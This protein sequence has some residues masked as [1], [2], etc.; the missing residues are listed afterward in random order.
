MDSLKKAAIPQ[1]IVPF[2]W[3]ADN[4]EEAVSFYTGCF[5][6]SKIESITRYDETSAK[7]SGRP[8][9]SLMTESFQ[10][11][12]QN[13]IALN[14]GPVFKFNPAISFYVNCQTE[15]ET[16][17]LWQKLSV[18]GKAL[19]PLDAY[20]FSKKFGW[21]QDQ[22]GLSWQVNFTGSAQKISPFLMFTGQQYGKAEEAMNFYTSLFKSSEILNVS[23]FGAGSNETEGA[24][25]HARFT[26]DG[27]EFMAM[28]SKQAHD[29]S[30]TPAISF[31][32]YCETQEEIDH[33]WNKLTDGGKEVECGW[34]EDRY[35][36]SWQIVPEVLHTLLNNSDKEKAKRSIK[37]MLKMKKLDIKTLE[38][39]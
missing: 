10:L 2:L 9:G 1:K 6:N 16:D 36:V 21:I 4:A 39:A 37:A 34:L 31:F 13:F 14:G 23:R 38:E 7:A 24:I 29:F 17:V 35:G 32:V 28:E 26:L 12:G 18:G 19:M 8:E 33:F 15:A 27:E 11:N 20:P 3:F 5:E 22:Y 25:M 30:F